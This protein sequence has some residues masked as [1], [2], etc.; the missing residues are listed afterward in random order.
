MTF[1]LAIRALTSRPVRS[2][3]LVCGFG[4][5]IAV[6]AALLGVGEVILDQARSPALRGGGHVLVSGATGTLGSARLIASNVFS[7]P[8]LAG[9]AVAFSPS[10]ESRLYLVRPDR[11]LAFKARGGIPSLER[12]IGDPETAGVGVWL[13]AS[14]DRSWSSPD[15]GE[16]LRAMDRFHPIPKVPSRVASWAEWLYFNGRSRGT[17]FYLTFFFGQRNARGNRLAGVRLQLDRHGKLATYSDF[18][19]ISEDV[20]LANAPEV[21][22]GQSRVHLEGLRYR[23]TLALRS[24]PEIES[25]SRSPARGLREN[26]TDLIGEL[27]LDASPGR[28]LPPVAIHGA[29]GWVSGYVVPVLSGRLGGALRIGDEVINL[30]DGTGY[31]DHNWGFWDGVSW[32]WGQVTGDGLSIVYG[33]VRPPGDA[34]DPAR[35]PGF[36]A[37]LGAGGPLG[38]SADVSIEETDDPNLGRPRLIVVEARGESLGLRMELDVEGAV[39]TPLNR[40]PFGGRLYDSS[41]LQ[42][43]GPCRVEGR[44]AGRRV[45]FSAAGSAETFR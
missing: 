22:I 29:G 14:T 44:I 19:E 1:R 34:A 16:V 31:H 38:I 18:T 21:A 33:R 37:V 5:G 11:I 2:G 23:V 17:R 42:L 8:S 12:A 4:F 30:D 20:L 7:S 13:D 39:R 41:F 10:L 35:V 27:T 9:R 3:V 25:G 6:M 40:G 45:S 26:K 36:L 28:S 15:P 32:Q 24:E 43:R